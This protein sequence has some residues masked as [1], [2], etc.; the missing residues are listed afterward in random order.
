MDS[1]RTEY[2][3][4]S[5]AWWTEPDGDDEYVRK[6]RATSL[7]E[8][9]RA[10][11]ESQSS[12]H[13]QNLWNFQLYSNRYLSSFDWGTDFYHQQSLEP[14]TQTTDNVVVQ[15][16]DAIV[17]EIGKNRPKAKP[18]LFS[19][20]YSDHQRARKLDKFLYG[21]FIRND[22]YEEAKHAL[23]NALV[24]S[25]GCFSFTVEDNDVTGAR[26]KLTNVFPD[27]IL[28]DNSEFQTMG[29][30]KTVI[31]RR[32]MPIEVA[33]ATYDVDLDELK[34]E[35]KNF[36]YINY[37]TTGHGWVVVGEAYRLGTPE[38]P[39][40]H[41]VVIG[42]YLVEDEEWTEDWYP[43]IFL[44]FQRPN[45]TFYT[46]S[47]V[48]MALPDQIRLNELNDVIIAC[49]DLIAKPRLLVPQGSR[50]NP[51]E[52]NDL[53]GKLVQFTGPMP[54]TPLKWD[55]VNVEL[56]N[57]RDRIIQQCFAKF[58][59]NPN[60]AQGGLPNAARL[61]SSAA[62]REFNQIQDNRLSDLAQ[63]YEKFFLDIAKMMVR[64]IKH[65][66]AAPKTVWFSGGNRAR[67]EVINWDDINLDDNCYTMILEAGSSF[68]MTPSA[69]RDS[70]EDQ[71]L[72]GVITPD[73]YRAQLASPDL[74][75]ITDLNAM[76]H[77][78]IDRVIELFESGDY[79][80]P[81]PEQD[82]VTG[83]KKMTLSVLRLG[84]YRE[85]DG[86]PSPEI[87]QIK[88][89]MINWLAEAKAILNR[90]AEVQPTQQN[91]PSES[92][93]PMQPSPMPQMPMGMMQGA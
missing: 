52:I 10:L 80:S 25:F 76:G 26:V 49:Q 45:K 67:A 22:V 40:R 29:C 85:K 31:H 48:E 59:V 20:S 44:H 42:D 77:Q 65:S 4:S 55:A 36:R 82:L 34:E 41:M 14:V 83:V 5:H 74:E 11:E 18:V 23:L 21:E 88:L 60:G 69:L 9:M 62:V 47:A 93:P 92:L 13:R 73:E 38:V 51:L 17:A 16:V 37:R 33:A 53:I 78:D 43:Y 84:R 58:G 81:I 7:M 72:K 6:C 8:Y 27:D 86:S 50:I 75:G 3:D 66:G 46:A 68:S 87:T 28:I 35:A 56:Y 15:I 61:D 54:P 19:A 90:G 32:V 70:L 57:E 24:C 2:I 63:R 64:V 91:L 39:G 30:I 79:E 89:N 12:I 1:T 71:L